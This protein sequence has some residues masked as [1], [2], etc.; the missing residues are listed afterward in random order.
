[1][2]PDDRL[3]HL[4][5]DL[6]LFGS[7]WT[8]RWAIP[9]DQQDEVRNEVLRTDHDGIG[10]LSVIDPNTD[11]DVTLAVNWTLVAVAVVLGDHPDQAGW[12]NQV[13]GSDVIA[14]YRDTEIEAEMKGRA[15]AKQR[16]VDHIVLDE[17]GAVVSHMRY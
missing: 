9:P 14:N 6:L 10:I 8:Q 4:V 16:H 1:M 12:Y 15:M 3:E 5:A 7:G 13:T 17:A 11:A 2:T